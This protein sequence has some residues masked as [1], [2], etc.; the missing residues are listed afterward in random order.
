MWKL[1]VNAGQNYVV[2]IKYTGQQVYFLLIS[3]AK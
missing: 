2:Q 3:Q 1:K